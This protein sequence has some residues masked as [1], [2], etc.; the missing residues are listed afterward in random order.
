MTAMLLSRQSWEPHSRPTPDLDC[1]PRQTGIVCFMA[2]S[3]G[4]SYGV[5]SQSQFW[6]LVERAELS[7]WLGRHRAGKHQKNCQT[8]VNCW[9]GT[10]TD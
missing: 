8:E 1:L 2:I 4:G 10:F 5:N 6:L 9:K 3:F 7:T